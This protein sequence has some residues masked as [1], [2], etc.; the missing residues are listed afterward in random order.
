M[1]EA[2]R[3]PCPAYAEHPDR[4]WVLCEREYEHEGRHRW[5]D[6][7][8]DCLTPEVEAEAEL[9]ELLRQAEQAAGERYE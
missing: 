8:W 2:H 7:E 3:S 9:R 5:R 6:M 4:S 1:P